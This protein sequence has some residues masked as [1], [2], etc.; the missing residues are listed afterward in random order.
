MQSA[1]AKYKDMISVAV[2][3]YFDAEAFASVV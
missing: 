3:D 1:T 2:E